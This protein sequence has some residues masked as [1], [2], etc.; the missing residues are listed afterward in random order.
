MS[1]L[2]IRAAAL[3]R[4]AASLALCAAFAGCLAYRDG[5]LAKGGGL[6]DAEPS[7]KTIAVTVKVERTVNG[8]MREL[9]DY[10]RER[11]I[12]ATLQAYRDSGLFASVQ[13][14]IGRDT[15][16]RAAVNIVD[17]SV[18]SR[19]FSYLSAM[20]LFLFPS[21]SRD[22]LTLRTTYRDGSGE[23]VGSFRS[24]EVV[25]TWFQILLLPATPFA[26]R[27]SV[28]KS[29]IRDLTLATAKRARTKGLF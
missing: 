16:L 2:R 5:P 19:A 10:V 12:D 11:W 21:R 26:G 1:S 20:S 8:E 17:N 27:D 28:V 25:V 24:R 15:D 9:P 18:G 23:I 29:T 22:E 13:R 7:A 14:G 3:L 4:S 6:G